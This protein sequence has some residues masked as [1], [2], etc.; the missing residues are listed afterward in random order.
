M[1]LAIFAFALCIFGS[2][3]S[4]STLYSWYDYESAVYEYEKNPIEKREEKLNKQYEKMLKK[5]KGK[6][7]VVPP[8]FYAEY[9]YLLVKNGKKAEGLDYM[10][11]EIEQYPESESFISRIIS[12]LKK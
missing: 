2:C 4:P 8:G 6:R 10:N 9:G 1:K 12:Q 5:Q 11:K 3:S 7:K